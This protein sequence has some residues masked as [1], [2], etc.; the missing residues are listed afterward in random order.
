MPTRSKDLP[1]VPALGELGDNADDKAI[2]GL[3][4]SGGAVGRAFMVPPG[5]P[6][7]NVKALQDGFAAMMKDPEFLAEAEKANLEIEYS[8]PEALAEEMRKTLG[9]P[10]QVIARAKS[11]FGR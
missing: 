7:A 2:L 9:T 4:A 1:D 6:A 3:Y 5:T 8:S 10:A 11:I